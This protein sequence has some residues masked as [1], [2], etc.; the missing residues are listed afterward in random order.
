M[1]EEDDKLLLSSMHDTINVV[2]TKLLPAINKHNENDEFNSDKDGFDFLET[3]NLLMVSYLIDLTYFVSLKFSNCKMDDIKIQD[4]IQRLEEMRVV[5]EKIRPME[6]KMGYQLDKILAVASNSST[7]AAGN[8]PSTVDDANQSDP[9]SYRP[10]PQN[11]IHKKSHDDSTIDEDSESGASKYM[12]NKNGANDDDYL[13]AARATLTFGGNKEGLGSNEREPID[14][15]GGDSSSA[16]YKAPRIT[17]VPFTEMEKEEEKKNLLLKKQR[18]RMRNS[19]LLMTIKSQ[20]GDVPDEDDVTGGANI[21]RQREAARKIANQD[22]ER[23]KLEEDHMIRLTT[24]RKDKKLRNKIMRDE[25]SNLNAIADI[26]NLTSGFSAAFENKK[27][28]KRDSEVDNGSSRYVNGKR[29]RNDDNVDAGY[30][31]K[32]TKRN[33]DAKNSFQKTLY[34]MDNRSK[35]KKGR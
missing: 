30:G 2:T 27:T 35:K 3:K 22:A 23:T 26:G 34:G 10:N 12:E 20:L 9:L 5:L 31:L 4:C 15:K 33:L 29:R 11:M 25:V 16:I 18:D 17:S 21:G 32:S 28:V 1:M 13:K 6:K 24:T 14:E 7:F 19:E 8:A